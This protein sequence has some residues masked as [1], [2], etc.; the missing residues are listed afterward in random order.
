MA[1]A[2]PD[3]RAN[4]EHWLGATLAGKSVADTKSGF[5]GK[6]VFLLRSTDDEVERCEVFLGTSRIEVRGRWAGSETLPTLYVRG[7]LDDWL[8][9]LASP[10]KERAGAL[11]FYGPLAL[12]ETLGELLLLRRGQIAVRAKPANHNGMS[13]NAQSTE[14]EAP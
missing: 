14:E 12:L 10:S 13:R 4:F 11:E 8:A 3:S 2:T 9:Y 6:L 7:R 5:A 1:A